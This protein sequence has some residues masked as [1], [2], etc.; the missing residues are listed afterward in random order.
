MP[1][2][3]CLSEL[4]QAFGAALN[5][6]GVSA[7]EPWIA[8]R[9]IDPAVRLRI[10]RH[11][12]Y[13]N[14]VNALTVSFPAVRAFLGE[15]CFDGIATRHAARRGSRSGNLQHYGADF[16][17]FL[18]EQDELAACPWVSEIAQLEWLRQQ[19][20]LSAAAPEVDTN[21]LIAAI[22]AIDGD[23]QFRLHPHV[24]LYSASLP[25][26]DLW[27][28]AQQP[29]AFDI[30]PDPAG[31]GQH[32]LLWRDG[33]QVAMCEL[34]PAPAV[35]ARALLACEDLQA[36]HTAAMACDASVAIEELV[37]PLLENAL[38][39]LANTD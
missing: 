22:V 19:S 31:P 23:P 17:D 27:R 35:F 20:A 32:I 21:T 29:N 24:R 13:A 28:Y 33:A 37:R 5:D 7:L 30:A 25:V 36:A 38:V 6:D 34:L 11:A 4:Q 12:N 10:Y 8:A 9:G 18:L 1:T 39:S 16:P 3:P 26:L 15:E 2:P 14:H